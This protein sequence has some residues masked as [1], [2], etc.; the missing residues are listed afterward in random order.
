MS[1]VQQG[2]EQAFV[3]FYN[4]TSRLVFGVAL[5]VLQNHAKAE[6]VA[7]EVYLEV[8]RTAVRYDG[9][10]GTTTAW[11]NVIAHRRAIDCV[12]SVERASY[13]DHSYHVTSP[14]SAEPDPVDV[15]VS[16]EEAVGVR[17]ALD[18]LPA[19]QREALL[20]AYF[21]GRSSREVAEILGIPLGTAKTRI[22]GAILRLRVAFRPDVSIYQPGA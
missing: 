14:I 8:W 19:G 10:R 2:D 16:R 11:L 9:A 12:R 20:L 21:D 7:Q 13:R 17:R 5:R 1:R 18:G 22:R 3:D 6:E 15:V 4:A